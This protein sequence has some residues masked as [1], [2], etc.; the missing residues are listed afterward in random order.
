MDIIIASSNVFCRELSAY[1]LS[2]AGYTVHE[3]NDGTMLMQCLSS[4][5][6]ELV[7]LDTR[8]AGVD[9]MGLARDIQKYW[10]IPIILLTN[11]SSSTNQTSPLNQNGNSYLAWPFQAEDLLA[12]VQ[13]FVRESSSVAVSI[14]TALT[15]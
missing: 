7:I 10:A 13:K 2:E 9:S 1:I 8:L 3:V 5:H 6:A 12:Q 4:N 14:P 11:G 15:L